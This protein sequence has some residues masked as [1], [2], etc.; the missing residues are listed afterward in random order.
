MP[1][2]YL[3]QAICILSPIIWCHIIMKYRDIEVSQ[4]KNEVTQE[5]IRNNQEIIRNYKKLLR[6]MHVCKC[7]YKLDESI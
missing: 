2:L 3:G 6:C 4:Y 1:G 5:T 7:M